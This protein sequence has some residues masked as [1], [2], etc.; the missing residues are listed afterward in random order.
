MFQQKIKEASMLKVAMIGLVIGLI[1][2]LMGLANPVAS[3]HAFPVACAST[4]GGTRIVQTPAEQFSA[5]ILWNN[6]VTPVFIG[7]TDVDTV[8][9]G[10]P[11]CTNLAVCVSSNIHIDG[12]GMFCKVAAGSTT[13]TALNGK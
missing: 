11:I 7:G 9:K 4:A 3:P 8:T 1:P 6:S 13:I 12:Y 5:V 2:V 10:L